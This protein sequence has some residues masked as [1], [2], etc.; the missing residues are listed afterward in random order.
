MRHPNNENNNVLQLDMEHL[1]K[2]YHENTLKLQK[3]F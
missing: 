1:T 2:K 3:C